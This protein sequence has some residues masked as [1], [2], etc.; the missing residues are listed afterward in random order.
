MLLQIFWRAQHYKGRTIVNEAGI[1]RSN[2][3]AALQHLRHPVKQTLAHARSDAFILHSTANRSDNILQQPLLA[4][5]R[6]ERMAAQYPTVHFFLSNALALGSKLRSLQH[7]R[8]AVNAGHEFSYAVPFVSRIIGMIG[9]I[10]TSWLRRAAFKATG[11]NYI[12]LAAV[13]L[14]CG[15]SNAFQTAAALY[16]HRKG[17]H[18]NIYAC[19]Q[20]HQARNVTAGAHTVAGNN[21]IGRAQL[22]FFQHLLKHLRTQH[23]RRDMTIHTVDYAYVA[24]QA[25]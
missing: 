15:N 8:F 4:R 10:A 2:K 16:V 25:T 21:I 12:S 24:A 6:R 17:R 13:Y 20:C 19:R 9:I 18:R 1:G 14:C 11:N 5:L 23:L 22:I 7:Y 3:F